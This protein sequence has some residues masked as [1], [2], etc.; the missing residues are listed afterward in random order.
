MTSNQEVHFE[1]LGKDD[2]SNLLLYFLRIKP[3]PQMLFVSMYYN[4]F[5]L[6]PVRLTFRLV[7]LRQNL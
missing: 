4:M 2:K 6:N 5:L 7:G 3:S 1:M